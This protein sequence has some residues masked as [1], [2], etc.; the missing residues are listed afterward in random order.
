MKCHNFMCKSHS[1]N[2]DYN[3]YS[4]FP[5]D[6]T[7]FGFVQDCKAR[8]RYNQ[9]IKI[10]PIYETGEQYRA[11]IGENVLIERDKYYGRE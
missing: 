1:N 10:K 11:M 2:Y 9:I 7:H 3:C 5:I 4:V 6:I 8:K